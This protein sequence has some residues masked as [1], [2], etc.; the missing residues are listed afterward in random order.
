MAI[1]GT[2]KLRKHLSPDWILSCVMFDRKHN[3]LVI[4]PKHC[5]EH[6][7][8]AVDVAQDGFA[9]RTILHFRLDYNIKKVKRG[10]QDE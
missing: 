10:G 1:S 9:S 5:L 7:V 6:G 4:S 3:S 8:T 2:E